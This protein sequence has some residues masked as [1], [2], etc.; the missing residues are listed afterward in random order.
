MKEYNFTIKRVLLNKYMF[1]I[2]KHKLNYDKNEKDDNTIEIT[3]YFENTSDEES[4]MHDF[5]KL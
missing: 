2:R 3:V 1:T 5:N 4:F